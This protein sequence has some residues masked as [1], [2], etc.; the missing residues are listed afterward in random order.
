[1]W[2]FEG[3]CFQEEAYSLPEKERFLLLVNGKPWASFSY[4]PGDEV[5]LALGHL[6]LSGVLSGLEGVRWLVGEGVVAVDL[7]GA[8]MERPSLTFPDSF[9]TSTRISAATTPWTAWQGTCSWRA[10][11]LPC[12][13]R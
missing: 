6:F 3:G 7:P 8:Y 9:S 5:Y 12:S 11:G 10:Y 4:T 1:M 2:R 13:W